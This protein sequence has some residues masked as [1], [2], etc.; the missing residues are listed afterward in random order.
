MTKR[1][2]NMG[3]AGLGRGFMLLLPTLAAHPDFNLVAASDPRAEARAQ[4]TKDFSGRTYEQVEALCSDPDVEVI[5]I[6]TPH[7]FHV[8]HVKLAAA[9]GKHVLVEKPMALSLADCQTMIE[10]M[11]VA[12]KQLLVGH[13]HSYDAPYLK[14]HELIESGEF[15]AVRMI[16]AMNFTDFLYRPRRPEEL[17]TQQG[18]GVVFSQAAHQVDIVRLLGG[19]RVRTVRSVVG[20]WD[21]AR[22]TEGAYSTLLTFENGAFASM[23]YSGYAHFDTDEFC[24]WN[25][26]LGQTRDPELYG[27]TRAQLNHVKNSAQEAALKNNRTY[28]NGMSLVKAHSEAL[29]HNHFGLIVASCEQADLRP[30]PKGVLVYG[31]TRRY[32]DALDPPV[33]PRREVLDELYAAVVFDKKP[34]HSG[35]WGLAT[36]EVCLAML[37]SAKEDR[38]V[39]LQYQIETPAISLSTP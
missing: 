20:Q 7:Q 34:I 35:E 1:T 15:G 30:V 19:G 8:H 32:L 9:Y 31:N 11:R 17:D 5:Y 38:E 23:T 37:Q 28:G 21:P 14:T 18:G 33:I 29:A 39:G 13:S 24:E 4:F 22:P 36:M 27:Q 6:A 10:V 3:V 26:E 25:G 16:N 2:L 12:G